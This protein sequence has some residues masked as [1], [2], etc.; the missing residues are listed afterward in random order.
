VTKLVLWVDRFDDCAEFYRRLLDGRLQHASEEFVE[1]CSESS[2]VLLH[3]MPAEWSSEISSPPELREQNPMKPVFEV[4]SIDAARI[5]VSG[6]AGRIFAEAQE[7]THGSSRYCDGF[8]P[9]G[10][11]IQLSQGI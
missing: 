8:D 10:N 11:I 1:V 7:Q 6:L 4:K 9:D 5:A 2:C 3:R